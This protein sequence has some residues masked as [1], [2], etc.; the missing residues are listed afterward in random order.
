[1]AKSKTQIP[2]KKP[3]SKK[4]VINSK[5]RWEV[6]CSATRAAII[7]CLCAIGT[8]SIKEIASAL[9]RSAELVHHH[10]PMLL[11]TGFVIECEPRQLARHT[12]RV[13]SDCGLEWQFDPKTD[14][15]A[16]IQGISRMAR[17]WSRANERLVA[18]AIA[19]KDGKQLTELMKTLT[20]RS[21][22]AFLRP[23][24]EEKVRKHLDAIKKIF[25]AERS[26][27]SGE[28]RTIYW[29]YVPIENE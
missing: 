18:D 27:N 24:A 3:Q 6:L 21:E 2:S 26:S 4:L 11:E 13:F 10:M 19:G 15:P 25:E 22:S 29:S 20:F 16:F 28:H 23:A 8:S 7:E 14:P 1:M 12:E 17:A 9:G 5:E